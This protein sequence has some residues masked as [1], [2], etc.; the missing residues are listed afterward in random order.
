MLITSIW[1]TNAKAVATLA[2]SV[3]IILGAPTAPTPTLTPVQAN[4]SSGDKAQLCETMGKTASNVMEIRQNGTPLS[5]TMKMVEQVDP[6][7]QD[8]FREIIMVAY[9]E[10]R[11]STANSKTR[12][13]EDYRISVERECFK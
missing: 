7:I 1:A 4:I 12:A 11:W 3:A 10:P 6:K 8:I 13:I 9:D 2:S 5:E